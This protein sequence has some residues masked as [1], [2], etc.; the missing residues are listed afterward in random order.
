MSEANFTPPPPHASA[1][2][3]TM[4]T[5]ETLANIYFEPGATFEALR[6]RPRFL[7]AGLILVALALL[8]TAL[9]F[10]RVSFEQMMR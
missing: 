6:E 10:Q 9:L 2:A 4:S 3:P 8:I 1:G 7:V 5:P